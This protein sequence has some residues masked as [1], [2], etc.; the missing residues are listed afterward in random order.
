MTNPNQI[1][2]CMELITITIEMLINQAIM[3]LNKKFIDQAIKSM[4][5]MC[6]QIVKLELLEVRLW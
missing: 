4:E 5:S 3:M 2:K 1:H 6:F